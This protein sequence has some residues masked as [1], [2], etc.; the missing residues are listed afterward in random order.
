MGAVWAFYK[1]VVLENGADQL[2]LIFGGQGGEVL[3]EK[4]VHPHIAPNADALN[5]DQNLVLQV[6]QPASP[7]IEMQTPHAL[8]ILTIFTKAF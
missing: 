2:V 3:D 6:L 5:V 4:G 1:L 7:A 8:Q